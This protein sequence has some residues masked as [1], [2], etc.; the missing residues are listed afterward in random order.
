MWPT[1]FNSRFREIRDEKS[2][3]SF[4]LKV[5]VTKLQTVENMM[6]DLNKKKTGKFVLNWKHKDGLHCVYAEK[7]EGEE[8]LCINSW[9]ELK[10][11][12]PRI[13]KGKRNL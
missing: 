8:V 2:G 12:N 7:K 13:A 11:P 6:R 9:G 10:S 3:K 5:S 4:Q 1:N